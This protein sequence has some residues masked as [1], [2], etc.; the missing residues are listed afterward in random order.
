LIVCGL[1]CWWV[2]GGWEVL[3][4]LSFFLEAFVLLYCWITYPEFRRTF[5]SSNNGNNNH[6][7][8]TP[9]NVPINTA[10]RRWSYFHD[11]PDSSS[12]FG[13][14]P[15]AAASAGSAGGGEGSSLLK[16]A[17]GVAFGM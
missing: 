2:G 8:N 1:L 17:A 14:S 5:D 7:P 15:T 10:P 13:V 16:Q 4:G 11:S 9:R 12:S 6:D 3:V